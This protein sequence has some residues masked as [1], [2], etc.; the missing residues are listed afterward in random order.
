MN[1]EWLLDETKSFYKG[2]LM[3]NLSRLTPLDLH[4]SSGWLND[5]GGGG[6][7]GDNNKYL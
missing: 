4:S 1:V 6:D 3:S 2:I 7:D 5:C